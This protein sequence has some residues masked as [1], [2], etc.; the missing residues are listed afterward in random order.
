MPDLKKQ[1]KHFAAKEEVQTFVMIMT[2]FTILYL[3]GAIPLE[4][5]EKISTWSIVGVFGAETA[6][7]LTNIRK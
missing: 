7:H 4:L 6:D 5:F 2:L 1:W 3:T